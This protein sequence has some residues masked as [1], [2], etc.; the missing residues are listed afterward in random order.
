MACIRKS[1]KNSGNNLAKLTE[2]IIS[3]TRIYLHVVDLEASAYRFSKYTKHG[4]DVNRRTIE[5]MQVRV[6]KGWK[7]GG[8]VWEVEK[9]L[10]SGKTGVIKFPIWGNPNN[11]TL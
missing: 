2:F 1:V 4:G 11:A 8:W 7:S 5:V 10:G 3:K 9:D 6:L